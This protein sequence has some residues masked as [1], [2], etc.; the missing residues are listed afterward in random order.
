MKVRTIHRALVGALVTAAV[1]ATALTAP[2]S[3]ATGR[4]TDPHAATR[5]AMEAQVRAGVPGVLGSGVGED[6]VWQGSAGV[7]DRT[8]QRPREA[9]DRFRVGSITKAFVSVVLLQQEAEGRIRLD[10]T[11]EHWLPGVVRGH[12]HDGRGITVRQL[13]NHTSGIYN[14]T[15]DPEL[16][17]TLTTDFD[18]HRFDIHTPRQLVDI[19]MTHA[20]DFGPGKGWHYS[21]TNYVLAGMIAGKVSG[22][23]Y[24]S[25]ITR[26]VI[27]PLRLRATTL[28]GTSPWMP[29]PHGRAYGKPDTAPDAKI[30]DVTEF[31]PSWASSA[32]EIIS[33]TGD[34]NRFYHALLGGKLLPE[35]QQRE[36][37]TTVP[38]GSP[39]FTYGLGVLTGTLSCGVQVWAH[40]GGIPG[41]TS[42][43]ASTPD[44][45]HTAA[46]NFNADWTGDT[47][48]LIEA[49]YC[50]KAPGTTPSPLSAALAAMH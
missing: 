9:Q 33:T 35:R 17:K 38:T 44:G 22:R 7:A 43:V 13:L 6:G 25:E 26:R 50:G 32:G 48:A 12:G 47:S 37:L 29:D 34:L 31:N 1:T 3:A 41:S 16:L 18:R 46:F 42:V 28:P 30:R 2:A 11:V 15:E 8:T 45:R 40:D 14:Y 4:G 24:A 36:L 23:S 39:G 10:D 20:P 19:A 5:A 27:E 49:E 21:N